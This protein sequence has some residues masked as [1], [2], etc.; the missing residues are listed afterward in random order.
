MAV[1]GH[2]KSLIYVPRE[3]AYAT[4]P[5]HQQLPQSYLAPFQRYCRFLGMFP[6]DYI[7]DVW[8]PT[9]EDHRLIIRLITFEVTQ[10]I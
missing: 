10:L 3:N 7:A 2:P 8:A 4:I 9:S 5:S 1:Q 6:L